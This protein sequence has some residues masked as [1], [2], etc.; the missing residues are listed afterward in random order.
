VKPHAAEFLETELGIA[1][2]VWTQCKR[3][4]FLGSDA[5]LLELTEVHNFAANL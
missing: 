3:T 4:Q 5:E 1:F 2:V